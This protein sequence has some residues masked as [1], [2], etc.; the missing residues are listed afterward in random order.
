MSADFDGVW[1][2][3]EEKVASG[4]AP[5]MVAGIRHRGATE[6]FATGVRTLGQKALMRTDT[7]FRVSSLGKPL[8]GALAVSMIADGSLA[9]DDPV[10]IW[11]PELAYPRVLTSPDAPLEST[12]SADHDIT[13]RQLLTLTHGMGITFEDTP[14]ARAMD[15][16]GLLPG[17]RPLPMTADE[18]MSRIGALPLAHQPGTRWSYH[19][20]S[21]ILSALLA[22]AGQ[23]PLGELLR[24]RIT[25][26]LGLASTGFSGD[27]GELPTAYEPTTAGLAV[28]DEPGGLFSAPPPFETLGG[29]LVSTVPDYLAF[30]AALA[31]DTLLPSDLRAE[32]T[33]D[34]LSDEQKEGLTG[35]VGPGVSWGWQVSVDSHGRYGWT[36]G[37]GTTAYVDPEKD[38]IG[39]LFTQRLMAG[40]DED[41]SY[42]WEPVAEALE[43]ATNTG[44]QR[45]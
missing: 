21:E 20:G 9:L 17:P 7:P 35:M 8:A 27:P 33:K 30:L 40:P 43:P 16:A 12:V 41:F 37:A 38:L 11:L 45:D 14:L 34:Q 1:R 32:M 28:F 13:V 39:V 36:G 2:A 25:G 19:V 22:R 31:D 44:G 3:L 42:F 4:W 5:G 6:Y 15:A 26:P 18:Y 23:A 10:D 29:G 24:E